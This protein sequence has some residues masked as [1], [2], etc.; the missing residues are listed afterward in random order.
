MPRALL[1]RRPW[2]VSGESM[3][4]EYRDGDLVLVAPNA[5][6]DI[7]DV[8]VARHPFKNLDVIKYVQSIE[9]GY[10]H[11]HSPAGDDSR[12]F[13]RAPV[14]SIKGRVTRNLSGLRRR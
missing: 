9:D 8:V 14:G 1:R 2:R 13:G 10:V 11:L 4:P 12:V 3:V 5:P 7:G 6:F